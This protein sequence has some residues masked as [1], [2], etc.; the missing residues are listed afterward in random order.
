[1][2]KLVQI[3][4]YLSLVIIGIFVSG[5]KQVPPV[6]VIVP[7]P[8][9]TVCY[10]QGK[11]VLVSVDK[12][13]IPNLL[14]STQWTMNRL[15]DVSPVVAKQNFPKDFYKLFDPTAQIQRIIYYYRVYTGYS[16]PDTLLFSYKDTVTIRKLWGM[17]V[18]LKFAQDVQTPEVLAI[19]LSIQGWKDS[20]YTPVYDDPNAEGRSLYKLHIQLIPGEN[21]IYFVSASALSDVVEYVTNFSTGNQTIESRQYRFHNSTLEQSC[22]TCHE[23][24]PSADSGAT[25]KADCSICHKTFAGA[26]FQHSPVEMKECGTCHAWSPEKKIVA[27]TK[28]VPD[29]CYDCHTEKKTA[30]DSSA[31]P[32]PPAADCLTCHSQHGTNYKHQL[33]AD[34]FTLC[35]SCHDKNA[36][37]HP[38]GRH[39]VRFAKTPSMSEEISCVSC[40]N[41][42]GSPNPSLLKAGGGR[43]MI[44]L[45]CHDK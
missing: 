38:V 40:H 12:T 32:H 3:F 37:N 16:R 29:L 33:K 11:L 10:D 1:M 36:I 30:V 6:Q 45:Q 5:D 22:T 34:V 7:A 24:L 25:M 42:H 14:V 15:M 21:K 9:D 2:K 43:M 26:A 39:P 18:M 19:I 35:T 4:L 31:T 23:G 27:T 13:A 44:C 28:A 17:P 8:T 20:I 41:P